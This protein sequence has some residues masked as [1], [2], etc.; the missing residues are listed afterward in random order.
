M[1]SS[2]WVCR[3]EVSRSA[4]V[5]RVSYGQMNHGL[6]SANAKFPPDSISR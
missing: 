4:G 6:E 2:G 3:A 1:T 5:V